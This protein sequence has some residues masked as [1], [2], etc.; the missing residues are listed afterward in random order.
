MWKNWYFKFSEVKIY[1]FAVHFWP[2]NDEIHLFLMSFARLAIK[3][4]FS[5][6]NLPKRYKIGT[7]LV[8]NYTLVY[9]ITDNYKYGRHKLPRYTYNSVRYGNN[10]VTAALFKFLAMMIS[11]YIFK[12]FA[13][14]LVIANSVL[15][16]FKTAHKENLDVMRRKQRK[17]KRPAVTRN[18]TQDTWL[19][20]PVLCHWATVTGRLRAFSPLSVFD[21]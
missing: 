14:Q 10:V 5:F 3:F 16:I 2:V 9:T 8:Q 15:A 19:V 20:E 6:Q 4:L 11:V 13:T 12:I 18:R 7:K 1:T 21:S 17:V